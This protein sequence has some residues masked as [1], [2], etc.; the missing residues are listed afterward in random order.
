MAG[1]ILPGRYGEVSWDPAGATALTPIISLNTWKSD[2]KTDYEDVSCFGDTN[3]VY[4]PGL[5]DVSG[6]FGGFWN[7]NELA[8]FAAAMSP[9]PGMLQLTPNTNEPT[10]IWKGLAYMDAAID[11]T[12]SAPKVTGNFRAAG[13]WTVPGV[14]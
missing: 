8:L 7:S 4:V 13:K 6:S 9:T 3:K 12:M 11:C 1:G 5:M 10:F 2:F 14:P